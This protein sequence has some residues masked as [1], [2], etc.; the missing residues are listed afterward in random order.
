[1]IQ[2]ID[3]ISDPRLDDYRNLIDGE[4]CAFIAEGRFV[5]RTLLTASR[6][7][8]RSVLVT[9]AAL[10][11]LRDVLEAASAAVPTLPVLVLGQAE[12]NR[13]V[14]FDIHRGC[15]AAGDR[16]E[17][18]TVEETVRKAFGRPI[19]ILEGVNNHD[20]IGS[21]F[22]NAGAFGVGGVV[23]DRGCVDPLYRKAIRVS[24]GGTLRVPFAHFGD[25]GWPERLA[26]LRE[27]GY[28]VLAL[29][30]RLSAVN[31]HE[32][33]ASRPLPKRAAVMFGS[34]GVGLSEQA[35]AAADVHVR[36]PIVP[37]VDSLNVAAAAAIAL[38]RLAPL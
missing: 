11:S 28:S 35:L 37:G 14:G 9:D 21:I 17:R 27:A 7:R 8:A 4:R 15:L 1:M 32:F 13:V 22:R 24:M 23:M 5:V 33:G 2:R 25:E 34:E 6:F 26:S 16:G 12:M 10:E 30:P 3:D 20:N 38:H 29:T 18:L 31:I 36:I 19:V